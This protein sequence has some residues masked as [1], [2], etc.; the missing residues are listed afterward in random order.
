MKKLLKFIFF[1]IL[2]AACVLGYLGYAKYNE[3]IKNMPIEE[4]VLEIKSADNYTEFSEIPKS[5]ID[6]IVA[7]EDRRFY[8]HK[9]I[10]IIG[11]GRAIITDIKEKELAEGGSTITQQLA[12]NM[13]FPMDNSPVRKIAEMIMAVKLEKEYKKHE[14][15]ELYCNVIYY[16]KGCYN[17][18]DAA[19]E[20]FGKEPIDMTYYE[21]TLLA[22]IPNA[23]SVYSVDDE[24]SKKRQDKVL[25]SM[26]RSGYIS[27][28][29]M[30]KILKDR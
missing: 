7:V 25:K 2:A 15:L 4:K 19:F 30:K 6:A 18:H 22:G 24:L 16:G 9:G 28:K 23:P 17:I 21:A 10:D 1:I 29:E 26:L 20:Y 11:I 13:Y 5:F 14:I 3:A 27:E 12:K 8:K